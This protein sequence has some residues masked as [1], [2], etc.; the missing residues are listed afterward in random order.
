MNPSTVSITRLF[1]LT[2]LVYAA[3]ALGCG[4]PATPVSGGT[5]ASNTPSPSSATPAAPPV[6]ELKVVAKVTPD[7]LMAEY[8]K[9][10]QQTKDKYAPGLI[11]VTGTVVHLEGSYSFVTNK[12]P[13]RILRLQ[14]AGKDEFSGLEVVVTDPNYSS[15][16]G[17]GQKITVRGKYDQQY[18]GFRIDEAAISDFGQSTVEIKT[19]NEL[20]REFAKDPAAAAKKYVGKS[21]RLTGVV[22]YFGKVALLDQVEFESDGK[23]EVV[24]DLRSGHTAAPMAYVVGKEGTAVGVLEYDSRLNRIRLTTA[25]D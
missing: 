2:S 9:D 18:K 17:V 16:V 1:A 19:A 23:S 7:E 10:V 21:V 22:K 6:T 15:K 4:K 12:P 14:L 25:V 20:V 24:A 8:T 3:A 11:E 13:H 5:A